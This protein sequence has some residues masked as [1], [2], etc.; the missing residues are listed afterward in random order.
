MSR[1]APVL[2]A[3]TD[4]GGIEIV[5]VRPAGFDA[6]PV[7]ELTPAPIVSIGQLDGE[8]PYLFG[9]VIDAA[10]L[11]D[12][13]IVVADGFGERGSGE[14][15]FFDAHGVFVRAAGRTGRGPGEFL[16]P[17]VVERMAG[18]S[19]AVW[20]RTQQKVSVLAPN[21]DP[22]REWLTLACPGRLRQDGARPCYN[23]IGF[24][25][26]ASLLMATAGPIYAEGGE[27]GPKYGQ[28]VT[29]GIVRERAWTE[30]GV[31]LQGDQ[32]W[33]E[34]EMR[35]G[36]RAVRPYSR[37]YGGRPYWTANAE[38]AVFARNDSSDI[39]VIGPGD[40]LVRLI[41]WAAEPRPV[42]AADIAVYREHDW[43][44]ER[45]T[46]E[47]WMDGLEPGVTVPL[48]GE[49]R[50]DEA[51]RLWVQNY[52]PYRVTPGD[53][54]RWWTVLERDGTP[55]ARVHLPGPDAMT[56]LQLDRD[57]ML[58][59]TIDSLGVQRVI[60]HGIQHGGV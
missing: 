4:S 36:L 47:E 41:R 29:I 7:W 33:A 18:D 9:R 14:L 15:R 38:I 50:I 3:R 54:P 48:Y 35:P 37:M 11:S 31:L 20:D 45:A 34:F 60:V 32:F 30:V 22:V 55:A 21:G 58:A 51:G 16:L 42:G 8:A 23:P 26:D 24:L 6:L 52:Y 57:A 43:G 19:I 10:R 12:G 13:T 25:D 17:Q 28:P 46:A 27:S 40:R 53:Q 2:V 1:A 59:R 39:R 5:E 44:D 49:L 56:I